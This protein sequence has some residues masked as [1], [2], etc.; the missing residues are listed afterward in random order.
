MRKPPTQS[1]LNRLFA[2]SG[3]VCAF[4][5]CG[6][7]LVAD[8]NSLVGQVCH[9]EAANSGGQRYNPKQTDDDRR[10]FDNL[11]LLC[12]NHHIITNNVTIYTVEKLK[13][14]KS[15]HEAK[16]K[17]T[18]YK[19]S[20]ETL[21]QAQEMYLTQTNENHG[22]GTQY[23]LQQG[24]MIIQG[25]SVSETK[26]YIFDVF[27]ASQTMIVQ[28]AEKAANE[29]VEKLGEEFRKEF[30]AKLGASDLDRLTEPDIQYAAQDAITAAIRHDSARL[31]TELSKLM[32]SRI[33]AK[34]S[35]V[36]LTSAYSNAIKTVG[37]LSDNHLKIITLNFVLLKVNFP[38]ALD[39]P[40]LNHFMN[41]FIKPFLDAKFQ[42]IEYEHISGQGCGNTSIGSTDIVNLLRSNYPHVFIQP[43]HKTTIEPVQLKK[44]DQNLLF[45]QHDEDNYI[46]QP[47]L[48]LRHMFTSTVD[49]LAGYSKV[50]KET[51]GK[52]YEMSIAGNDI[53]KSRL[54]DETEIGAELLQTIE[55][56]EVN[57]LHLTTTGIVVA[58]IHLEAV[59]GLAINPSLWVHDA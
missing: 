50:T 55:T 20:K 42:V 58:A 34:D 38:N 41:T 44:K 2:L 19:P 26:D 48:R 39:M 25:M 53:I 8:D 57:H 46:I 52:I 11:L 30:T 14:M 31:R 23:N 12:A 9:I 49:N 59:T 33:K 37:N 5:D 17:D 10:S 54:S 56:G 7:Q 4:A 15:K 22:D 1:T 35:D 18:Q 6:V 27:K 13:A 36:T 51:L 47:A 21:A 3:N 32:V 16:H 43:I 29:R 45:A 28:V 40:R 24:Q